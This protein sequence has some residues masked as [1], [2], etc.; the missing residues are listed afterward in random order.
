[1]KPGPRPTSIKMLHQRLF[2]DINGATAH[3]AIQA[4]LHNGQVFAIDLTGAQY[5][6]DEILLP[7]NDFEA[8][9]MDEYRRAIP[10]SDMR[11]QG[12]IHYR[13]GLEKA[14]REN[15]AHRQMEPKFRAWVDAM[16][17]APRLV[18]KAMQL[19]MEQWLRKE[20]LDMEKFFCLGEEY[21]EKAGGLLMAMTKSVEDLVTMLKKKEKYSVLVDGRGNQ[22]LCEVPRKK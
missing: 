6:Y 20:E 19:S 1:M 13:E 8:Q 5:G 7:W 21:V 11:S 4:T 18:V 22:G 2:Q 14:A 17:E 15:P 12:D 3:W 9:R 10:F 16:Y